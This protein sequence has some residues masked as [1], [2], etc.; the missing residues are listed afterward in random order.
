MYK[1]FSSIKVVVEFFLV[2][3]HQ[4]AYRIPVSPAPK[5]NGTA[6]PESLAYSGDYRERTVLCNSPLVAAISRHSMRFGPCRG[7]IIV[8]NLNP[9]PHGPCRGLVIEVFYYATSTR[10]LSCGYV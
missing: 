9:L 2:F 3:C 5:K 1:R 10:L 6:C 7:P 8:V 4:V